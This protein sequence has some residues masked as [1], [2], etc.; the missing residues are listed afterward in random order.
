VIREIWAY[1]S[2]DSLLEPVFINIYF[3]E[4]GFLLSCLIVPACELFAVW[5]KSSP[6]VYHFV[7][8]C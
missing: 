6:Y 2:G 7:R 4:S 5:M 1:L 8:S 3:M